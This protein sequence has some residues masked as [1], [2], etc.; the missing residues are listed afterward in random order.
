MKHVFAIALFAAL[1]LL[2]LTLLARAVRGGFLSKFPFF[3]SYITYLLLSGVITHAQ[4]IWWPVAYRTGA[5]FRMLLS[6]LAE[7]VVI[8]EISDHVFNPYPA[9]RRLGRFL[10]LSVSLAFFAFYILPPFLKAPSSREILIFDLVKRSSLAKAV[11]IIVLLAAARYYRLPLGANV[12]GLLLGFSLYLAI[13]V[14]NFALL[15]SYGWPLYGHTAGYLAPVSLSLSLLV[16]TVAMW[17]YKPVL[18]ASRRLAGAAEGF[19]D[20]L[21][22]QLGKAN[23]ALV[24]L[25]GR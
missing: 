2:C 13:N 15:E 10:T 25:L 19:S 1:Y 12:S 4:Y 11:L 3:Y 8:A 5:W 16:W 17:R 23:T 6:Y 24:R 22:D 7:F 14:A 9:L 21:S 20:R 18:P